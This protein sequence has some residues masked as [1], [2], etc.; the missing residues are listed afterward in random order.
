[1]LLIKVMGSAIRQPT[2]KS[3]VYTVIT[4]SGY[5]KKKSRQSNKS[6]PKML[7]S[8]HIRKMTH[9]GFKGMQCV[10]EENGQTHHPTVENMKLTQN[11]SPLFEVEQRSK[12]R[13]MHKLVISK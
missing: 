3:T 10:K 1:M 11:S 9:D 8:L 12:L 7:I 5:F 2:G 4:A 6:V 13:H